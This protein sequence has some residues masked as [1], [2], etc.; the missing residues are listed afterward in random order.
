MSNG[1]R[2]VY[3][4]LTPAGL[5]RAM[6][7]ALQDD[8][9]WCAFDAISADEFRENPPPRVTRLDYS[10]DDEE[11]IQRALWTIAEHHPADLV[12]VE[13]VMVK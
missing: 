1:P 13:A 10:L 6:L 3:L 2:V 7:R 9:I 12:W 8:S 4:V 5:Q 11:S